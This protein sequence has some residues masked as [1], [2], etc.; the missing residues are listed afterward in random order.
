MRKILLPSA[1]FVSAFYLLKF[2]INNNI[3]ISIDTISLFISICENG[4]NTN[5]MFDVYNKLYLTLPSIS[6]NYE[7]I[8]CILRMF[9]RDN[10]WNWLNIVLN[11]IKTIIII[12]I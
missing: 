12:I 11:N 6:S 2:M 3:K 5:I 10:K 7:I 4:K 8:K 1:D 9:L